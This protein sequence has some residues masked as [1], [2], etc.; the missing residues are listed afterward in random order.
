KGDLSAILRAPF[1]TRPPQPD[2]GGFLMVAGQWFDGGTSLYGDQWVDRPPLL[3]LTFKLADVL[4]GGVVIVHLM[5]LGFSM[6]TIGAAWW[7][8]RIINGPKG[9][10]VAA[11][12][13]AVIGSNV[14]LGAMA[15]TGELIAGAF[16]MLSC[17]LTL[18]AKYSTKSP[19]TGIVLAMLAGL[20]ASLAFLVKQNFIDAG[21]FAFT[22]LGFNIHKTWRLVVAGAVGVAIP[23]LVTAI[24]ARSGEGP[25]LVRL[26][27][28]LFRFRHR[29]YDILEDATSAAPLDR[30][31][32][33]LVLFLISG[34]VF[35]SW[36]LVVT[37]LKGGK[38]RTLRIA[39]LV[40]WVYGVAGVLVGA[41]WWRHY[42]LALVPV[43]AMGT[44]LATKR[45]SRRLRTHYAATFAIA[46][47][48]IAALLAGVDLVNDKVPGYSDQALAG[49]L[50]AASISGDSV[51][52]AYGAPNIIE[53]SGLS[54][55]Y[56]YS[57]SL[58]MRG[59]DSHLKYLVDTLKG[60]YAP[61]W[62]V[63]LGDFNWWQIDTA[64]FQAVRADRYHVVATV[65]GH[66]IYLRDDAVRTLPPAPSCSPA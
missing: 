49:Y 59:R 39:L 66:D 2:E 32:W 9:A 54:T 3:L 38:R 53:M 22:L 60:P 10:V 15:M 30:L 8:G 56:R 5:A 58:P 11:L 64:A 36:Q 12:V 21:I 37:C 19:Q 44:A 50:R 1:L 25:G 47:S 16:V 33:L 43:L 23:L 28:A 61:T 13:A 31:R 52:V 63:E 57:W 34:M 27:H 26:W 20:T 24:W 46:A 29:A 42:L 65:C 48:V 51:F 35:L 62:L 55:P 45:S 4:G 14:A 40:M 17:A 6:L 18:Q 7:A 41:S